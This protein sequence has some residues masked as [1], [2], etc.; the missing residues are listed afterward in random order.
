MMVEWISA[1]PVDELDLGKRDA[2]AVVI[3]RRSGAQ[4][5][6]RYARHRDIGVD[7]AGS[8]RTVERRHRRTSLPHA[9]HRTV[10]EPEAAAGEPDLAEDRRQYDGHPDRLLAVIG[11]LQRPGGGDERAHGRHPPREAS[12]SLG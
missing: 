12:N 3:D 9:I 6:V 10:A 4:Q 8:D 11:A 5:Q 7:R 2:L 1:A